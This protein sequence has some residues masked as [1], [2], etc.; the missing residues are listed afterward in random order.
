MA[1]KAVGGTGAPFATSVAIRVCGRR[2]IQGAPGAI[3]K[4]WNGTE[5]EIRSSEV[6]S[7]SGDGYGRSAD[8]V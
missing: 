4:S 6:E 8:S 1:S 3:S 7:G 2:V 5:M